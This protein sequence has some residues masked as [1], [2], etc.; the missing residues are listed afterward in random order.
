MG[1]HIVARADELDHKETRFRLCEASSATEHVHEGSGCA[2]FKGHV[3]IILIFETVVEHD[4]VVV[5]KRTMYLY[6]CIKLRH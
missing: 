5:F 1:M 4:N 6:F 3:D 2:E